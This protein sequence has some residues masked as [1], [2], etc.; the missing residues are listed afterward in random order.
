ML[1][2]LILW[3]SHWL[4]D[5]HE[6]FSMKLVMLLAAKRTS[7]HQPDGEGGVKQQ[8]RPQVV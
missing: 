4:D 7:H 3:G 2:I 5:G 8:R 1:M 6:F